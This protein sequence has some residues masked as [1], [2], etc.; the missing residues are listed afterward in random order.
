MP[1]SVRT[2]SSSIAWRP[3]TSISRA[4][5]ARRFHY[6]LDQPPWIASRMQDFFGLGRQPTIGGG[7]VPLVIH[8][9]AP[10]QR[11]SR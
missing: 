5:A 6:V 3:P 9:L 8:L 4:A 11:P 1:A 7:A 2:A 10:N